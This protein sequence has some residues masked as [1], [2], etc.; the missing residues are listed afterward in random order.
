MYVFIKYVFSV[1]SLIQS[2]VSCID[3]TFIYSP[4]FADALMKDITAGFGGRFIV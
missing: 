1:F 2:C 3:V 4:P